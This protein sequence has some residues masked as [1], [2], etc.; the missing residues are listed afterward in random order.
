MWFHKMFDNTYCNRHQNSE[1]AWVLN[2]YANGFIW[3]LMYYAINCCQKL[4]IYD[5]ISQ[6]TF[7]SFW[8]CTV[9][10]KICMLQ[11]PKI[12]R[13]ALIF[14]VKLLFRDDNGSLQD[15]CSLFYTSPP[16]Q[17][18][19]KKNVYTVW[20]TIW[21]YIDFWPRSTVSG[22]RITK[23]FR[24]LFLQFSQS[25][26]SILKIK[27]MPWWVLQGWQ[28]ITCFSKS[29]LRRELQLKP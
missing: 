20:K 17:I 7:N 28:I 24:K 8:F 19:R 5:L 15:K 27:Q 13:K 4:N 3:N 2:R 23:V 18:G 6:L 25:F 21:N 11:K 9:L 14:R 29:G 1:E 26:K 16:Q 12:F 22:S 10:D